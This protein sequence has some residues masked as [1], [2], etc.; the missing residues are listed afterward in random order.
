MKV[1]ILDRDGVINE[2][3]PEYIKS[4]AEWYPIAGSIEAI[5]RLSKE[6][7]RVFIATNQS[8]IGRGYMD[9]NSL[10]EIHDR[11]RSLCMEIG[12][13]IEG[14]EYAPEH[15]DHASERRKPNPGM[16]KDIAQRLKITLENVPFVGDSWTDILA[17]R[18]AGA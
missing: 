4:V 1:I 2:D 3:S 8:A 5:A 15:P 17:A 9:I 10:S 13:Y 6:G 12:G 16:L 7:W 18:A 14:I 11:L